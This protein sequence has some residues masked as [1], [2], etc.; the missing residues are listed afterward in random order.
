MW[1]RSK[2]KRLRTIVEA[3]W[4][5]G[6]RTCISCYII[7]VIVR[8]TQTTQPSIANKMV[9]CKDMSDTDIKIDS[10]KDII[11]ISAFSAM[12]PAINELQK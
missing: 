3:Q 11:I 1:H 4:S 6:S 8:A 10:I 2:I 12:L 9:N 5:C 7:T